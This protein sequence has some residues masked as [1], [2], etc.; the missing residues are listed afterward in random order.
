MGDDDDE[1]E[2]AA[3]T[4]AVRCAPARP[5]QHASRRLRLVP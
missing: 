4:H 2:D 1:F 3:A 5:T